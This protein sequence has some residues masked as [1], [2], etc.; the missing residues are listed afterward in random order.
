VPHEA[1]LRSIDDCLVFDG[2]AVDALHIWKS[3]EIVYEGFFGS[4]ACTADL[5]TAAPT[6]LSVLRFP[7]QRNG[8]LVGPIYRPE[9]HVFAMLSTGPSISEN[10]LDGNLDAVRTVDPLPEHIRRLR[11]DMSNGVPVLPDQIPTRWYWGSKNRKLPG[12]KGWGGVLTVSQAFRAIIERFEPGR[13]QFFPLD[14][15]TRKGDLVE[16]RFLL[17]ICNAI[18]SLDRARSDPSFSSIW[19]GIYDRR[20]NLVVDR[21]KVAQ[22]HLWIDRS[23]GHNNDC[24]VSHDL[25]RALANEN[26]KDLCFQRYPLN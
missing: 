13:H 26:A 24:F 3:R 1:R 17:V 2:E 19:S 5:L 8:A 6:G 9:E 7:E 25:A 23:Y 12:F 11:R 10:P 4:D 15:V 20:I 21:A 14:Y 18:D 22:A 16:K